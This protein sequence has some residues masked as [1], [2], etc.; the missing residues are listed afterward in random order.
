MTLVI[1]TPLCPMCDEPPLWLLGGGTQA[2]CGNDGCPVMTWNPT[3]TREEFRRTAR[4]VEITNNEQET[5]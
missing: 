5:P 1:R 3:E 4:A 2:F